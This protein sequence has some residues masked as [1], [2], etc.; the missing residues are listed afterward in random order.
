M[1]GPSYKYQFYASLAGVNP[2]ALPTDETPYQE[3]VLQIEEPSSDGDLS[4]TVNE[5][6]EMDDAATAQDYNHQAGSLETLAGILNALPSFNLH[7]TPMV[8]SF[9]LIL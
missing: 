3:T 9:A 5:K 1:Q 2:P 6:E 4:L 7:A 8:L